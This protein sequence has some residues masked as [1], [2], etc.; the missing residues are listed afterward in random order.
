[1]VATTPSASCV[2]TKMGEVGSDMVSCMYQYAHEVY[3]PCDLHTTTQVY[4]HT[5]MQ[6]TQPSEWWHVLY[7]DLVRLDPH[8]SSPYGDGAFVPRRAIYGQ[9]RPNGSVP[10]QLNAATIHE[11]LGG[12]FR[13][14]SQYGDGDGPP[15]KTAVI[16]L[17]PGATAPKNDT[18]STLYGRDIYGTVITCARALLAP[19]VWTSVTARQPLPPPSSAH[20]RPHVP[21]IRCD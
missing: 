16:V 5:R 19:D 7:P 12:P 6:S 20:S 15:S 10:V 9:A 1:V 11:V 18:A 17:A 4:A 2:R 8:K 21:L 14:E 13:V 3:T